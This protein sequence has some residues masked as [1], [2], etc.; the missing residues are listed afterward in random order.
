MELPTFL[1]GLL[2]NIACFGGI[3]GVIYL[4]F[5]KTPTVEVSPRKSE[6]KYQWNTNF[7]LKSFVS[8]LKNLQREGKSSISEVIADIE[9][10][11]GESSNQV[12][13]ITEKTAQATDMLPSVVKTHNSLDTSTFLLYLGAFVFSFALFIFAAFTWEM[14][15]AMF[16]IILILLVPVVFFAVF[17]FLRTKEKF[18]AASATF[19]L[20]GAISLGFAGLGIWNFADLSV[21]SI[22]FAKYWLWYGAVLSGV[23]ILLFGALKQRRYVTLFLVSLYSALLSFVSAYA[24]SATLQIVL[25]ML[26]NTA[27]FLITTLWEKKD[28]LFENTPRGIG[29]LLDFIGFIV[30]LQ[31][32]FVGFDRIVALLVILLPFLFDI[33][34]AIYSKKHLEE[35]LAILSFVPRLAFIL[36]IFAVSDT[37]MLVSVAVTLVASV[38]FAEFFY[39]AKNSANYQVQTI[40]SSII[41]I[42]VLIFIVPWGRFPGLEFMQAVSQLQDMTLL[43]AGV[44]LTVVH[45]L[46]MLKNTAKPLYGFALLP[47]LLIIYA[48]L[49]VN[50]LLVV[51]IIFAILGVYAVLSPGFMKVEHERWG[52]VSIVEIVLLLA[53]WMV[54]SQPDLLA[55]VLVLLIVVVG[56][57]ILLTHRQWTKVSFVILPFVLL[58]TGTLFNYLNSVIFSDTVNLEWSRIALLLPLLIYAAIPHIGEYLKTMRKDA[59]L[60]AVVMTVLPFLAI[61]VTSSVAVFLSAI[62]ILTLL[63]VFVETKE[64]YI[65][66]FLSAFTIVWVFNVGEIFNFTGS[67]QALFISLLLLLSQIAVRYLLSHKD[68]A[69]N[70]RPGIIAFSRVMSFLVFLHYLLAFFWARGAGI[71]GL[72]TTMFDSAMVVIGLLFSSASLIFAPISAKNKRLAGIGLVLAI[73]NLVSTVEVSN[74]WYVVPATMYIGTLAY[75]SALDKNETETQLFEAFAVAIQGFSLLQLSTV[76][77][78]S[79]QLVYGFILIVLSLGITLFGQIYSRK[80]LHWGGLLFLILALYVRLQFIILLIPWWV[81]LAIIGLLLMGAGIVA[82]AKKSS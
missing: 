39:A 59:T 80:V 22:D 44:L 31:G 17:L 46:P 49:P 52:V 13:P 10:K 33:G 54:F 75:L 79:N 18:A 6:S 12:Q 78:E 2:W 24:E 40:W 81:Y 61:G 66:Y 9:N 3:I 30:V 1:L 56:L 14:Y 60:L 32:N 27:F 53:S 62:I 63:S 82:V 42:L 58:T 19:A 4:I 34:I 77:I 23:Y 5:R 43:L 55:R 11:V 69:E 57:T 16:K 48:I 74:Q 8:Y 72:A 25:L 71:E 76:G 50:L 36:T 37:V 51:S 28:S 65:G 20:V 73:W 7:S 26:L 64:P 45:L 38:L 67:L 68:V 41:A 47:V 35:L 29:H 70:F 21:L 15:S